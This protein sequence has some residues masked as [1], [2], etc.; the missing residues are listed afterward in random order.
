MDRSSDRLSKRP[1]VDASAMPIERAIA[2]GCNAPNPHNTQAWKL[3]SVSDVETVLYVDESRLLPA[4]DPPARQIHIGCSCCIETLAVGASTM[5][6]GTTVEEFPEGLYSLDGVGR[7]PVARMTLTTQPN[8]GP[9]ALASSIY[10]RRTGSGQAARTPGSA[11]RLRSSDSSCTPTAKC[12]KSTRRWPTCN[13]SSTTSWA[14]PV[15]RRCRW[16]SGW[17]KDRRLI[18][19]IAGILT[20]S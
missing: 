14:S 2:Y 13:V 18:T 19:R 10:T 7:K 6:Y 9:N 8:S 20:R 5:G 12:S 17:A 4:T 11:W 1:R 15:R 16:R 3:H